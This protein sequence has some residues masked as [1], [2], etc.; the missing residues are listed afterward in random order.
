MR[1]TLAKIAAVS[2]TLAAAESRPATLGRMR[3]L[4]LVMHLRW[5]AGCRRPLDVRRVHRARTRADCR[6][7]PPT[8]TSRHRRRPP[9]PRTSAQPSGELKPGAGASIA[10]HLLDRGRR[11]RSTPEDFGTVTRDGEAPTS[12]T[13][14]PS[15]PTPSDCISTTEVPGRRAG[16]SG[17]PGDSAAAAR[18]RVHASGRA[19]GSTST[20][21]RVEIGSAAR[22]SGPVRATANGAALPDGSSLA[23]GDYRCRADADAAV[24]RQLRAPLRGPDGAPTASTDFGCLPVGATA[25]R[26]ACGCPAEPRRVSASR[27]RPSPP[28]Q[29]V[30]QLPQLGADDPFLGGDRHVLGRAPDLVD[31]IGQV[32]GLVGGQHHRV[33]ATEVPLTWARCS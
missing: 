20:A 16:L 7:P 33:G 9:R 13:V 30:A 28:Q 22:R 23:F 6:W 4:L 32:G 8:A 2:R 5:S 11:N 14:S 19:T 17:G 15:P 3:L 25:R 21:T 29:R 1:P 10:G 26:S 27:R 31:A 12:T 24:L 18:R